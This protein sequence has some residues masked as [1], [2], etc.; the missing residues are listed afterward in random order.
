MENNEIR[1]GKKNF[2][3]YIKGIDTVFRNT[4]VKE[5]LIVARG[6]YI[7]RAVDLANAITSQKFCREL[8]L[9]L[10]GV[11]IGS[12]ENKVEG[13]DKPLIISTIEISLLR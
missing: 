8:N 9:K 5:G 6:K 10:G 12:V 3:N 2:I 1:V 13:R 4:K 7:S 11:K